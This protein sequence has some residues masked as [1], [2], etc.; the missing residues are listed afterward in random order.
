ME[1]LEGIA[2]LARVALDGSNESI[3]RILA[4]AR[5]GLDMDVAFVA[6]FSGGDQVVQA[7]D[8]DGAAFGL[9][10]GTSVPLEET[11]CG[12][13][14]RGELPSL[15]ADAVGDERTADLPI[16]REAGIG[17]YVGVPVRLWDGRLYGTLCCLSREAEPSLNKRD[18][19]FMR[20]LAEIVADQLDRQTL[21]S[22][23]RRLEWSRI[24]S[25]IDRDDV[26][27]VFQPVVDLEDNTVVTLEALARFGEPF[28]S[29][30]DWFA[31]AAEVG[32]GA[33]LELTAIERAVS[34][35][36][37]LPDGVALAINVSP[38]TVLEPRFRRL[39]LPVAHRLVIEMTEHAQVEDYGA[40]IA[41][42][43]PLRAAGAQLAID[44]VGAGFA[45]MRHILRLGPDILKLDL[46]L[47]A[48]IARDP[49]REALATSLVHFADGV[50]A[51]ITAEGIQT[52]A[53]LE[54]L[55]SLGVHHGQG[56]FFG[57]PSPLL[58]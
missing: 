45:S 22:E 27:V 16:T 58:H 17:A 51:S 28:R 48:E 15:V 1:A 4:L 9:E 18:L 37:D 23:K 40:L 46:S 30:A 5:T 43:A 34:R 14:V 11:Y 42:L 36:D 25:V 52:A 24:R 10:P 29:P 26:D 38:S 3:D 20:V 35:I 49:A 47:T 57:R 31:E 50:G 44:D 32:L 8:G 41:A 55:R 56:F 6:A 53:D 21:E 54:L 19:R 39:L 2:E 33:E 13:M 12:Q 7:V